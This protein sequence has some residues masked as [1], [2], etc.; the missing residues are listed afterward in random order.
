MCDLSDG[1]GHGIKERKETLF[2]V[3][4]SKYKCWKEKL[5]NEKSRGRGG[6]YLEAPSQAAKRYLTGG[7]LMI[8][9]IIIIIIKMVIIALTD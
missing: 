9:D 8:P 6:S 1:D 3:S 7:Y 2:N 5:D 4:T